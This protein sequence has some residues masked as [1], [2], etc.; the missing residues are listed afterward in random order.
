M[1][2]EVLLEPTLVSGGVSDPRWSQYTFSLDLWCHESLH[3]PFLWPWVWRPWRIPTQAQAQGLEC[4]PAAMWRGSHFE[5][6][7]ERDTEVYHK[8]R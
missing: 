4:R 2:A 3:L 7:M 1:A 8:N 6:S 5:P